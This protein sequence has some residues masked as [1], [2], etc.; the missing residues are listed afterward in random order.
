MSG[1]TLSAV[2]GKNQLES[3]LLHSHFF[4]QE[5]NKVVGLCLRAML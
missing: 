4:T 2:G 3:G 1:S 5:A